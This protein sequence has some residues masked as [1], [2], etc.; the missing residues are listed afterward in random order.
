[1]DTFLSLFLKTGDQIVLVPLTV[2]GFIFFKRDAWGQAISLYLFTMIFVYAL[3]IT[4]QVPLNPIF[5]VG[6]YSFP[7]GLMQATFVYFG[8]LFLC[9]RSTIYRALIT[10]ILLGVAS[11]LLYFGYVGPIDI[12]GS[13]GFGIITLYVFA[14]FIVPKYKNRPAKTSGILWVAFIILFA[15]VAIVQGRV[16]EHLWLPFFV[17]PGF[18]FIWMLFE[19]DLRG[20]STSIGRSFFAFCTVLVVVY[21][22]LSLIPLIKTFNYPVYVS[23]LP[24]FLVGACLPFVVKVYSRFSH[25]RKLH[26]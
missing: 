12:L 20:K 9:T 7:S 10:F 2:I 24:W 19:E 23:Y 25:I 3:K 18:A 17:F 4:F 1:M 6:K 15:G 8:W 21:C 14:N 16:A 13:L 22:L 26:R 11:A 5:G